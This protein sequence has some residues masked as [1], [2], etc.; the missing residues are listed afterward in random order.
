MNTRDWA[1]VLGMVMFYLTGFIVSVACTVY[2]GVLL[3]S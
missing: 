1:Y 3:L 2:L